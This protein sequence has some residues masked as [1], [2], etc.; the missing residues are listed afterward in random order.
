MQSTPVAAEAETSGALATC[1]AESASNARSVQ[2]DTL[3]WHVA[4]AAAR[5]LAEPAATC[6]PRLAASEVCGVTDRRGAAAFNH[7]LS[8][9]HLLDG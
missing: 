1:A 2:P 5:R 6:Q 8:Q 4:Q 9:A 3:A 7:E